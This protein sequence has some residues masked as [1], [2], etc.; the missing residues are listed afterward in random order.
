MIISNLYL[1]Q[2]QLGKHRGIKQL[3]TCDHKNVT[4]VN[5]KFQKYS[6]FPIRLKN[7][8]ATKYGNEVIIDKDMQS[9]MCTL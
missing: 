2:K 9:R 5:Y 8:E 3:Q 4:K 1:V 7:V 6:R